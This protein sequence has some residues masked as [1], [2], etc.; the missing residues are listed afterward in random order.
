MATEDDDIE[1]DLV[2]ELGA[3]E[4]VSNQ[5]LTIYI[6]D[7]D[8]DGNEIGNQRKWVL[9]AARLFGEIGGGATILPPVEGCWFNEAT[10]QMV[11]EHPVIVYTFVNPDRFRQLLPR[12]RAFVHRLGRETKQG[13]VAVQFG[14][15]LYRIQNFEP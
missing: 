5:T 7:K 6:P 11:W 15:E 8:R 2:A 1:L 14:D 9:E 4:R 12:L 10:Q 13:E 3:T